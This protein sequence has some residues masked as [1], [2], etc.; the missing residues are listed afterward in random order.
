LEADTVEDLGIAPIASVDEVTRLV[1]RHERCL[2]ID[3]AQYA[4]VSAE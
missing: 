1:S 4:I 3:D 2:I